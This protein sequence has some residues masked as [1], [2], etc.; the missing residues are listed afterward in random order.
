MPLTAKPSRRLCL[1]LT[2]LTR[3]FRHELPLI[4]ADTDPQL[5][6][7]QKFAMSQGFGFTAVVSE[8]NVG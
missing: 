3:Y 2:K 6:R 1:K 5:T 8:L 7:L 4:L